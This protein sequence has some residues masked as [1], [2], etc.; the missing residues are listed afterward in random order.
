MIMGGK[1]G[2]SLCEEERLDTATELLQKAAEKNVCIHLPSDSVIA[3]K[4]DAAAQTSTAPSNNIPDGWMGLDIGANACDQFS[5]IIHRSKT[6]L[7]NGP[8]GGCG[9]YAYH[10]RAKFIYA[11]VMVAMIRSLKYR[12]KIIFDLR[13]AQRCFTV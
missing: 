9:M 4:F 6:L 2:K 11:P 8:M 5:H 10:R 7:W 12:G 3:D 13:C 1:I